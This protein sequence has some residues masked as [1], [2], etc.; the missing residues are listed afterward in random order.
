M[1]DGGVG[2]CFG[3]WFYCFSVIWNIRPF[4]E[5][6]KMWV[7]ELVIGNNFDMAPTHARHSIAPAD[8]RAHARR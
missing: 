4:E 7:Y 5:T 8:H 6:K 1:S 3:W 2:R